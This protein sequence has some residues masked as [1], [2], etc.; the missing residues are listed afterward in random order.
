MEW[1][2]GRVSLRETLYLTINLRR[3][4]IPVCSPQY[5]LEK[6]ETEK[7]RLVCLRE[8]ILRWCWRKWVFRRPNLSGHVTFNLE[9]RR[10]R[11]ATANLIHL[12]RLQRCGNFLLLL[13]CWVTP[14][15][16]C[17]RY[18][19]HVFRMTG[20]G[21]TRF[22]HATVFGDPPLLPFFINGEPRY[23]GA[24]TVSQTPSNGLSSTNNIKL[25]TNNLLSWTMAPFSFPRSGT[26]S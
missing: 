3:G 19:S 21:I 14:I 2:T 17:S 5:S 18:S 26:Y 11:Y 1:V 10:Y 16:D 6:R 8:D 9:T 24:D 7:P 15:V 13:L 20:V 12:L 4:I 25:P 23:I 22:Q